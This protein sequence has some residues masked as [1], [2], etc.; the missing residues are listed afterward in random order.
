M[1]ISAGA[2]FGRYEIRSFIGAGGFGEVYRAWDPELTR[3]VAVKVIHAALAK[4]PERVRRFEQEA[5]AAAAISHPNILTVHDI[6][7]QDGSPYIVSELLEGETLHKRLEHE[8][9]V[10][11]DHAGLPARNLDVTRSAR[12]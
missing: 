3:E 8:T 7:N 2:K 4:D 5:R 12:S 9:R 1:S 10:G 11:T 6:G